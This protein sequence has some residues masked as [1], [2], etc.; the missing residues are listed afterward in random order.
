[1]AR[2]GQRGSEG[3]I[4]LVSRVFIGRMG[5]IPGMSNSDGLRNSV[6]TA[7]ATQLYA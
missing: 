3:C 4:S 1:M 7:N 6:S 2:L 5:K